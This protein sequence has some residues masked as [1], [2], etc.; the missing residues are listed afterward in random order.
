MSTTLSSVLKKKREMDGYQPKYNPEKDPLA[1]EE[2]SQVRSI[3]S[4]KR[5]RKE[6][7]LTERKLLMQE[8]QKQ[9]STA[10]TDFLRADREQAA[11]DYAA[12]IRERRGYA[13]KDQI[14]G[15]APLDAS[16]FYQE[17][18]TKAQ[19]K[20]QKPKQIAYQA[21]KTQSCLLYTSRCV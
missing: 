16:E 20:N 2:T 7:K 8:V 17:Q 5:E 15:T 4:K 11:K 18:Q 6:K 21:A 3:L 14:D 9:H 10:Q 1:V 13:L 12:L 19:L